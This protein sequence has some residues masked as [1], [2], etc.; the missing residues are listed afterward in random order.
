M[1]EQILFNDND[2]ADLAYAL[3]QLALKVFMGKSVE[4][5]SFEVKLDVPKEIIKV[6]KTIS[7]RKSIPMSELL[8]HLASRGLDLSLQLNTEKLKQNPNPVTPQPTVS[9]LPPELSS[10]FTGSN[11]L[12]GLQDIM[13]QLVQ[14]GNLAK[15]LEDVQKVVQ[16]VND[17][18]NTKD[19]K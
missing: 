11:G 18:T 1:K 13:S 7:D 15:Q 12:Q 3:S 14:L 16:N 8:S 19:I 2:Q 4:T 10:I 5:E 17:S 6:I 9:N